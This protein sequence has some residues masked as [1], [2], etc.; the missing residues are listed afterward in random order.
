[1]DTVAIAA[2]CLRKDRSVLSIPEHIK[3]GRTNE[4]WLVRA[5]N[6]A[7]VVR[8]SNRETEALQIDRQSEAIVL[9]TASRAGI[10]APVLLCAPE[11]HLLVT[12]FISGHMWSAREARLHAN[13]ERIAKVLSSLHAL[14]IPQGAQSI[15]LRKIVCG[16]WNTLMARGL[17]AHVGA[18]D[19]RD[20]A[21][22]LIARLDD[23]AQSCLCHNDVHHLNVIDDG[24]LWLID[25]EYAGVGDPYFDLASVCCYHTLGDDARRALL[26]AY[27][28]QDSAAS[29]E[30][31][32]RM[33]WVFNYIRDLWFAVREMEDQ[34]IDRRL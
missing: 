13:I 24:R 23:D 15:N 8:L 14:P 10:G 2:E 4:S 17:S 26:R 19:V 11:R 9:S 28:G 30:R 20:R 1:M 25:W 21:L 7:V 32:Q 22:Q 33:C 34:T 29:I 18:P 3:G 27:S 5:D 6:A 12:Q 16:Y 31:L